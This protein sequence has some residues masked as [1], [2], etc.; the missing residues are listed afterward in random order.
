MA[1]QRLGRV[2]VLL[3]CAVAPTG[4]R[5]PQAVATFWGNY[6]AEPEWHVAAKL[7]DGRTVWVFE[8]ETHIYHSRDN[9]PVL[10]GRTLFKRSAADR[11]RSG[12]EPTLLCLEC[13]PTADQI[14]RADLWRI[15]SSDK[16]YVAK[17]KRFE[18]L[19]PE[20]VRRVAAATA[21]RSSLKH[22]DPRLPQFALPEIAAARSQ[23]L[24]TTMDRIEADIRSQG[25]SMASAIG[26]AES[27]SREYASSLSKARQCAVRAFDG[28]GALLG[29]ALDSRAYDASIP[30]TISGP[31]TIRRMVE[32]RN[33][34]L[35]GSCLRTFVVTDM[36][37]IANDETLV[38]LKCRSQRQLLA[39]RPRF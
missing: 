20:E 8:A 30:T 11:A 26:S 38:L 21:C 15:S 23:I 14:A 37:R 35:L 17:I 7:A 24:A 22:L 34:N 5:Q 12:T 10:K 16:T 36:V 1:R 4:A 31:T 39:A 6:L 18:E 2:V 13:Q 27:Q 3:I 29:D 33:Q 25:I 28:N 19:H 32:G 9:C